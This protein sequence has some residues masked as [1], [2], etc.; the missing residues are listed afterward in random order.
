[1]FWTSDDRYISTNSD[2][3]IWYSDPNLLSGCNSSSDWSRISSLSPGSN[4][5]VLAL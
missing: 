5:E 2:V 4:T 3:T 1:M